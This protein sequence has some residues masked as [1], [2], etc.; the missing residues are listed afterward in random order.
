MPAVV[1]TNHASYADAIL[2]TAVLPEEPRFAAK[3]EFARQPVLGPLMR[4]IGVRFVE[5]AATL[6]A[7]EDAHAIARAVTAGESPVLFPEGTFTRAPGLRTFHL[8]AFAAAAESHRPVVPI[9]LRGTRS[10]LRDG[11]WL[12]R[13]HAV[14]V[15]VHA[16]IL[17]R[18]TGWNEVLRL[19]DE[20]RRAILADCGEPDAGTP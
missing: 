16:P 10:V 7:I 17:P 12:P 11:S 18:D 9:T 4:R 1:V 8:G 15:I 5:R 3:A 14:E 19:R 2:L 6:R 20:A 13:R